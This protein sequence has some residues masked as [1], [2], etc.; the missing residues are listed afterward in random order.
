MLALP[1]AWTWADLLVRALPTQDLHAYTGLGKPA[2]GSAVGPDRGT[3]WIPTVGLQVP[4]LYVPGLFVKGR[5]SQLC[6]SVFA[7]PAEITA[8]R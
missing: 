4:Q 2:R 7:K 3:T 1:Y 6:E 8:L 5:D